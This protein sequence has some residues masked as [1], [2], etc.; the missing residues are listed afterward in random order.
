[1]RITFDPAKRDQTL[2]ERGLDFADAPEVF[3]EH[4]LT[5]LDTREDHGE[6]RYQT[7]GYLHGELVM[8]VWTPRG[9]ARHVFSMRRTHARE[10]KRIGQRLDEG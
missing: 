3:A 1:M 8:V 6:D 10:Q 5:R 4:A 9:D 7:Y 2:R